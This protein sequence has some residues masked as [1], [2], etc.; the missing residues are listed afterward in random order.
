MMSSSSCV[1]LIGWFNI[2]TAFIRRCD[3]SLHSIR[4]LDIKQNL[5]ALSYFARDCE[6]TLVG[7]SPCCSAISVVVFLAASTVSFPPAACRS[8][9]S[10]A[11]IFNLVSLSSPK[12]TRLNKTFF[13]LYFLGKSRQLPHVIIVPSAETKINTSDK[14]NF[15]IDNH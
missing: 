1:I 8:A 3:C 5:F 6:S 10:S 15:L 2:L 11:G 12:S 4:S 7:C 14:R 13:C 9:S